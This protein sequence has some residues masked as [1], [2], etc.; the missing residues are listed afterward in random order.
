[1]HDLGFAGVEDTYLKKRPERDQ[2]RIGEALA[3]TG[4]G[5][6]AF[7]N[8]TETTRQPLLG[9]RDKDARAQLQK[10][11][12]SSIE[13]A[14]RSGAKY[15]TTVGGADPTTPLNFQLAAAI[16]NLRFLAETA[17]KA[18]VVICTEP[19][20]AARMPGMLTPNVGDAYL[21][22]KAVDS[23]AVKMIADVVHFHM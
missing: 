2:A 23:P 3:R 6:G 11:L 17:D 13:T 10:E 15:L 22:A 21:L 4:M 5:I 16:D 19:V 8:N 12:L 1:L 18:G 9:S 20:N 7:V 14:K